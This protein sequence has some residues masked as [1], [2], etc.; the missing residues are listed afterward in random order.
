MCDLHFASLQGF[1][2]WYPRIAGHSQQTRGGIT[3]MFVRAINLK[4]C[5]RRIVSDLLLCMGMGE[6]DPFLFSSWEWFEQK[7]FLLFGL[8][9]TIRTSNL[10]YLGLRDG[11]RDLLSS[12]F[13]L[14]L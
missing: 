7:Y 14:L 3:M 9:F 2:L 4:S 10:R 12:R 6:R 13:N 8:R 1:T 11:L 5:D